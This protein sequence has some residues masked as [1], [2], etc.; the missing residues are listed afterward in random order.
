MASNT[1]TLQD[2]DGDYSDWIELHNVT[3]A[4][5]E[6]GD[7]F[8]S[9]DATKLGKWRF[10]STNIA[11]NGYLLVFASNK[12][13]RSAGAPLHTNFKLG[14]GGSYLALVRPDGKTVEH[15]YSPAYPP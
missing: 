9:D 13:R 3:S 6:L 4:S 10:P 8:V 11:A 12:D 1:R 7:W 15:H 14:S 2:E 5:V